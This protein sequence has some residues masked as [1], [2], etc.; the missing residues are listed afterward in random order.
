MIGAIVYRVH[1]IQRMFERK[2]SSKNVRRALAER[3]VVEDYSGEMTNPSQLILGYQG[4][5]PFHLVVSEKRGTNET[6]IVTVYL[7]EPGKWMKD[8]R[9]R[10]S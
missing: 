6:V 2:I 9:T 5:R 10:R 4:R 3:D 8:N 7:P 1:A